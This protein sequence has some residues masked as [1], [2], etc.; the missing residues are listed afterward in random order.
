MKPGN[1]IISLDFELHWGAAE[2]WNLALMKPYFDNARKIVPSTLQLFEANSIKAT[3]ATVGFLFA[4]ERAQLLECMPHEKP[5]YVDPMFNSYSLFEK[6]QVGENETSDPYHFAYSLIKKIVDTQGQELASHTFSHYYCN[7]A[8]QNVH[9][10]EADLHAAQKIARQNFGVE[11]KSLVFPKNQFNALY[12]QAAHSAGIKI[13]RSNPDVSFWQ[14]RK[15]YNPLLRAA[16]TLFPISKPLSFRFSPGNTS[17]TLLPASRFLRPYSHKEKWIQH[18]KFRRVK[19]EMSYAAKKGRNYHLWWH[20]HNFGHYPTQNMEYL[21]AIIKHYKYLQ[22]KYGF[23][24]KCMADYVP[25]NAATHL[26]TSTVSVAAKD[27]LSI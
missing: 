26:R 18:L 1:L 23:A 13:V 24:S 3:W 7:E 19:A 8:G 14:V 10:F 17:P 9:Q 6:N 4:R 20:P 16:D 2:R 21:A 12:L 25:A 22:N 27:R 5:V 15:K 11:L